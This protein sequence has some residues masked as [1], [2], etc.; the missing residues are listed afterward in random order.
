[1]SN[2]TI[3]VTPGCQ[4]IVFPFRNE[5]PG[6]D[7][8]ELSE[9]DPFDISRELFACSFAKTADR[10]EGSF[11]LSLSNTRDWKQFLAPGSWVLIYLS[12]CSA[13]LDF[14]SDP[15]G[16]NLARP[17]LENLKRQKSKLRGICRIDRVS[18]EASF[19]LNGGQEIAYHVTG[20]DI[21][22]CYQEAFC[23]H[24]VFLQDRSMIDSATAYL[25]SR[26]TQTVDQLLTTIHK[27]F[28][29]PRDFATMSH[30][31]PY[32]RESLSSTGF[33]FL[34]P[35]ALLKALDLKLREGTH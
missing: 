17:N 22:V 35:R 5:G 32:D 11:T 8:N 2:E 28:F 30:R 33:Q 23:F 21:G 25:T 20:R 15:L 9:S 19:D 14:P 34:L 1:M 31:S 29:S 26:P 7:F 18:V 27:L 6:F 24:N 3:S 12:E 16:T 13:D 4:V 10:P